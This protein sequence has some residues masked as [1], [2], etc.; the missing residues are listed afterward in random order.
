MHD[1]TGELLGRCQRQAVFLQSPEMQA[2]RREAQ[3]TVQCKQNYSS[4]QHTRLGTVVANFI[5][6]WDTRHLSV[7]CTDLNPV[8]QECGPRGA[9]GLL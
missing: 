6:H 3:A 7:R 1:G 9:K 8:A 4:S 5:E 2:S